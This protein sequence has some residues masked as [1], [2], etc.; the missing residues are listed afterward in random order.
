MRNACVAGIGLMAVTLLVTACWGNA[1]EKTLGATV[2]VREGGKSSVSSGAEPPVLGDGLKVAEADLLTTSALTQAH[3]EFALDLH[4]R[5]GGQDSGNLFFSPYSLSSALAMTSAGARGGTARQ[6]ASV[7]R[8]PV[9]EGPVVHAS[10]GRQ[11]A[12]LQG[13]QVPGQVEL[14]I[15]NSLWPDRTFEM[16]EEFAAICRSFY[17]SEIEPQDFRHSADAARLVINEWVEGRTR[18]RI[19][20]LIAPGMVDS[21]TALVLVNA[22]YFKGKWAM[23]FASG[24]TREGP[25]TLAGG[26][27][28][29]VPFMNQTATFRHGDFDDFQ[30]LEMPYSGRGLSMVVLLPKSAD[31]LPALESRLSPSALAE[32][33]SVARTRKVQV[34]FPRFRLEWGEKMK[35]TLMEMGMPVAFGEGGVADFSGMSEK[36]GLVI[37]E[38]VHKAFV[39]VT[40]EGTE[41]AAATG[42]T[43]VRTTAIDAMPPRFVA[44]RPFVFLIRDVSTGTVLFMGR[45]ANPKAK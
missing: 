40:E 3:M 5:L 22:I 6:M 10:L 24:E 17:G 15:A 2:P 36:E 30:L 21:S 26:E 32:W 1:P 33:T 35:K 7:L 42:V 23:P 27:K 25:F 39:E 44:D 38:V 29:T 20:D 19:R 34:G 16:R 4:A 12:T 11:A 28:V 41:A 13:R 43:M 8:L 18:S 14:N 37:S 45:L 9:G 31:E